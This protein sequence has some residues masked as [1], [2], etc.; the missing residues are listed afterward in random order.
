MINFNN[1]NLN[2][3]FKWKNMAKSKGYILAYIGAIIG[4][5]VLITPF[6]YH[7]SILGESYLWIWG[8]Y[9]LKPLIGETEFYFTDSN[10]FLLWGIIATLLI[11][12]ASLIL[13]LT[14]RKAGKRN[15]KYRFMWILCGIIYIAAPLIFLFGLSSEFPS[16]VSELFWDIY[17]FHFAFYGAFIAGV[18]AI[19]A[20]FI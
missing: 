19:L 20:G 17:K 11:F 8:F 14:A 9:T 5:V 15:R 4:I 16:W 7:D 1:I 2:Y 18:F 12:L 6:A 13:I 3:L 10:E